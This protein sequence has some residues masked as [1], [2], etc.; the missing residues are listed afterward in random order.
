[1]A[2]I[3][4]GVGG[5]LWGGVITVVGIALMPG[6]P[7]AGLFITAAG[8]LLAVF[9]ADFGYQSLGDLRPPSWP[10]HIPIIINKP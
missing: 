5:V 8:L 9:S 7:P 4:L 1:M 2:G 6:D 3:I 10:K